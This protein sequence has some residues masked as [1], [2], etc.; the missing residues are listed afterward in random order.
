[1]RGSGNLIIQMVLNEYLQFDSHFTM[2]NAHCEMSVASIFARQFFS[3]FLRI[4]ILY[5]C[6]R[7]HIECARA[8]HT[9]PFHRDGT[10]RNLSFGCFQT[11][12]YSKQ[13]VLYFHYTLPVL[14][15]H[16]QCLNQKHVVTFSAAQQCIIL[17]P[18]E[19]HK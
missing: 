9:C 3:F 13:C 7:S 19:G 6:T 15:V 1:M 17:G 18:E 14:C 8:L 10:H 2:C 5:R 11:Q 12:M 4:F 16:G